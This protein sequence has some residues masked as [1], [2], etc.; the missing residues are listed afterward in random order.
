M[1]VLLACESVCSVGCAN[2]NSSAARQELDF[3]FVLHYPKYLPCQTPECKIALFNTIF[4]NFKNLRDMN[5]TAD[6]G[7][8]LNL[9]LCQIEDTT[10]AHI[11]F[12]EEHDDINNNEYDTN[13]GSYSNNDYYDNNN[14]HN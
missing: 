4:Q 1:I 14:E 10:D 11:T 12:Y 8:P 5:V 2:I 6:N 3:R 9:D 7:E 13:Y